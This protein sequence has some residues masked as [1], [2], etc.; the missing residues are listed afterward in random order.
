[1]N[2]AVSKLALPHFIKCLRAEY[3]CSCKRVSQLTFLFTEQ[4]SQCEAVFPG[5][6]QTY[7][8]QEISASLAS[9]SALHLARSL[10]SQTLYL[11]TVWP[12]ELIILLFCDF[13]IF[14][15]RLLWKNRVADVP[16]LQNFD[17][18]EHFFWK[19]LNI[20]FP[21]SSRGSVWL[22]LQSCTV[23]QGLL[24]QL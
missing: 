2:S 4:R 6:W 14:R 22:I 15:Q 9:I 7:T 5:P 17:H 8:E 20:L 21:S 12:V 19:L 13:G 10:S 24:V 16:P 3:M 23:I 18:I 11:M 1:M